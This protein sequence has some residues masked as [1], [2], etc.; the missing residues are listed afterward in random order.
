MRISSGRQARGVSR[1]SPAAPRKVRIN[2]SSPLELDEEAIEDLDQYDSTDIPSDRSSKS[3]PSLSAKLPPSLPSLPS[4][5]LPPSLPPTKA[6]KKPL[7]AARSSSHLNRDIWENK[8]AS[9]G[10]DNG[11]DKFG[12][13]GKSGSL[14]HIGPPRTDRSGSMASLYS[15]GE[16]DCHYGRVAVEGEIQF[17]LSFV[18]GSEG[19]L[20]VNV[21][22]VK[23]LAG[24]EAKKNTSAT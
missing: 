24:V 10:H 21:Q 5:R 12:S 2:E 8:A 23:D 22:Q 7:Y 20:E 1:L 6:P 18:G 11:G 19:S 4:S 9:P 14:S 16:G 3:S 13:F 17:G 15:T